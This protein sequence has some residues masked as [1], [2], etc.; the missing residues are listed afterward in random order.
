MKISSKGEY[1]ILALVDLAL[2]RNEGPVKIRSIAERQDIPKK[3]LE[4]VLLALKGAGF[5]GSSRGKNGG[6]YLSSTPEEIT[7]IGVL[8]VLEEHFSLV[9][10]G[11]GRPRYLETFWR[12]KTDRIREQL[13]VPLTE[14]VSRKRDADDEM[15]YHI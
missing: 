1:G 14:L 15:M 11:R 8:D 10:P 9:D 5:V 3:Y 12:E 2:H 7:I 6:Y 13:E 4:Q